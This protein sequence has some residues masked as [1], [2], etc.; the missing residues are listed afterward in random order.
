MTD[1]IIGRESG[2]A[3][4]RLA[5]EQSGKT[6]FW[7]RPG[8][9]PRSVSRKHCHVT[10]DDGGKVEIE[11]ITTNNFMYVNGLDCKKKGGLTLSDKIELGPDRYP[12][13]L[14]GIIKALAAQKEYDI[15]HLREVYESYRK[16][17]NN[18]QV[19]QGILNALST[20]PGV[21][22]MISIGIA[23]FVEHARI[24]LMIIAAILA[25]VFVLIRIRNAKRIPAKNQQLE[26]SFRERYVCPNPACGHFQGMIPYKEL[27]K[28]KSCPYC[29]A[30]FTGK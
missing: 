17:R 29:K 25:L 19:R 1:L 13:D 12:L 10:I 2:E 16:E 5:I 27:L 4:P 28:N 8:S 18:M 26:D 30:K 15:S 23:V 20:L 22:S 6:V 14:D 7:G 24:V 21:L 9:V 11:D 3:N